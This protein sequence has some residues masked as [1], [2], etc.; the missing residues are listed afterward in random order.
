VLLAAACA[1]QSLGAAA[2]AGSQLVI[3]AV[4]TSAV[5][6]QVTVVADVRSA[7]ATPIGSEA[8]S[9][10]AG[11]VWL[12]TRV[13]PVL[14]D[15]LAVGLVVDGS[16]HGAATLHSGVSG[17]ANLLLQLPVAG[18][19]AAVADTSPPVVMAPLAVGAKD[20]LS[21]LDA[22]RPH[23]ERHTSQALTVAL[24]Q[25]PV[26]PGE[27]R[28]LL[29]FT[30]AAD[31]G[32]EPA[33]DL[34]QRLK[35]AHTLLAVVSTAADNAYW[36]RVT[37][38]TG[39]VLVAPQA[40]DLIAAFETLLDPLR[41]RYLLTFPAPER[42]PARVTVRVT[43]AAGTVSADAFVAGVS[44]PDSR[45][46]AGTSRLPIPA[47]IAA[48]VILGL[49]VAVLR[50]R[51]VAR[52]RSAG[53]QPAGDR[54]GGPAAAPSPVRRSA[55][56][57]RAMPADEAARAAA[58]RGTSA[59]RGV[60]EPVRPAPR[61]AAVPSP[62]AAAPA[63]VAPAAGEAAGISAGRGVPEPVRPAPRPAAAP[64]PPAATPARVAP[65]AGE[66]AGI[67]AGRGVPEPVRP[68]PRPAAAPP[69]PAATP[70]RVA[71]SAAGREKGAGPAAPPAGDGGY[72]DLDTQV[73]AA[74]VAVDGGRLDRVRAVAQLAL[75]APGRIDLLDRIV[76]T[77][78][79]P[80]GGQQA[81]PPPVDTALDLAESARRVVMG[82]ATLAGPD[83]VRVEQTVPP[84]A[85]RV[86]RTVLRLTKNGR[87]EADCRTVD[88]LARHIDVS[89]LV[90]RPGAVLRSNDS[91]Q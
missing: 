39:G 88:E 82:E 87:W 6:R 11:G 33:A 63:R 18:R 47:L 72:A 37:A 66:A 45:A 77:R 51:A 70:A 65:G 12:P 3:L 4:E 41:T 9:V 52:S 19:V 58:A 90:A 50:A 74:A 83:G 73:T 91:E 34:A 60:P 26:S 55:P 76:H 23:G 24:R 64:P 22:L 42:V 57:R 49:A 71:A 85:D 13:E 29:L 89:K 59:G 28:L 21:A 36:S 86:T 10:T 35:K 46:G 61:P 67:S 15:Q 25:L 30:G 38:A 32:G 84:G 68:A 62:P 81:S 80:A 53:R 5:D 69:P 56:P 1:L 8:F 7:G 43:T 27:P 78:R 16:R 20:A 17:P 40:T 14:S 44:T 75:A 79:R 54:R 31:A 48:V 2:T